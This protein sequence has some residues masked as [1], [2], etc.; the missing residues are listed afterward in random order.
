MFSAGD[1]VA[2]PAVPAE[3]TLA[4]IARRVAGLVIDELVV[5]IPILGVAVALGFSPGRTVT[6]TNFLYLNIAATSVAFCYETLM[7]V[8]LGRT[9]GKLA[10]GTRVV[11]SMDG[12]RPGW[13]EA[14]MRSLVPLAL[15]AIPQVGIF[16]GALVYSMAFWNP[17]R[18]GLHD[19]AAGTLVVLHATD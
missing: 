4:P 9:L 16:L 7:I 15:G 3:L 6:S 5:L 18:Q 13:S 2:N 11:R 14:V 1:D 17:L 12:A 8:L 19:R 10:L